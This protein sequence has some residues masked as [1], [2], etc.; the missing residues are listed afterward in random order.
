MEKQKFED[1]FQGLLKHFQSPGKYGQV[2]VMVGAGFSKNAV[3][4]SQN[5]VP[6]P[7]WD[8]LVALLAKDSPSITLGAKVILDQID[9]FEKLH[10]RVFLG[11]K[12]MEYV[13]W[14]S[15]RSGELHELLLEA[16][17]RDIFTTN[18]DN[19]IEDSLDRNQSN[20]RIS[21]QKILAP[22]ELSGSRPPRIIKLHGSFPDNQSLVISTRDYE[23]YELQRSAFVNTVRQ[24]LIEGPIVL[25][26][27]SGTDPNFIKW[28]SWILDN[29]NNMAQPVYFCT[30][31][32]SDKGEPQSE[33]SKKGVINLDLKYLLHSPPERASVGYP[34]ALKV[35]LGKIIGAQLPKGDDV[36]PK[37]PHRR[38]DLF[39]PQDLYVR[40]DL[41]IGVNQRDVLPKKIKRW[42]QFWLQQ[43]R[44]YPGWAQFPDKIKTNLWTQWENDL[45]NLVSSLRTDVDNPGIEKS[46]QLKAFSNIAWNMKKF[47]M[48][49][50]IKGITESAQSLALTYPEGLEDSEENRSMWKEL[51]WFLVSD[52]RLSHN[53]DDFQKFISRVPTDSISDDERAKL[54]FEKT[55]FAMNNC[56]IE[57]ANQAI[58]QWP[59]QQGS[60]KWALKKAGL[61]IELN[62]FIEAQKLLK[63]LPSIHQMIQD[64]LTEAV[65]WEIEG[66]RYLLVK[67]LSRS[68]KPFDFSFDCFLDWYE[69]EPLIAEIHPPE[70][71]RVMALQDEIQFNSETLRGVKSLHGKCFNSKEDLIAEV[72]TILD[73]PEF[74]QLV[75]KSIKSVRR[76]DPRGEEL[77]QH[78]AN[79]FDRIDSLKASLEA[80]FPRIMEHKKTTKLFDL[81]AESN[82][83]SIVSGFFSDTSD[84]N[85]TIPF[86]ATWP[87]YAMLTWL[88]DWGVPLSKFQP[89]TPALMRLLDLLG[90]NAR[91]CF[92]FL[93]RVRDEKLTNHYLTQVRLSLVETCEI[94]WIYDRLLQS[95][96]R[97][98]DAIQEIPASP[99]KDS[100]DL[101]WYLDTLSR[102][103]CR[104]SGK[105][106]ESVLE[107]AL[108][109]FALEQIR[110]LRGDGFTNLLRR[111]FD[112]MTDRQISAWMSKL[113]QFPILAEQE[114][115]AFVAHWFPNP[116][117]DIQLRK[118]E[119]P[120]SGRGAE[121]GPAIAGLLEKL[122]S[123]R[124]GVRG[125]AAFRLY[126]LMGNDWLTD[127]E[128]KSFLSSL[129][130]QTDDC[131]PSSVQL[132][133][134]AFLLTPK[135]AGPE[136]KK[137]YRD[138]LSRQFNEEVKQG[139]P[140][141]DRNLL[142][143]FTNATESLKSPDPVK[144]NDWSEL[145]F[146][147]M[148]RWIL[149]YYS[150]H[151]AQLQNGVNGVTYEKVIEEGCLTVSKFAHRFLS[152]ESKE[153]LLAIKKLHGITESHSQMKIK[154]LPAV[155]WF[156]L[157]GP[158]LAGKL[159]FDAS[160]D[161]S[162][163]VQL[164]AIVVLYWWILQEFS[165][166]DKVFA[167]ELLDL[168]VDAVFSSSPRNIMRNL[169]LVGDMVKRMQEFLLESQN[170]K[171][172]LNLFKLEKKAKIADQ[173]ELYFRK[174]NPSEFQIPIEYVM[175][176]RH[177]LFGTLSALQNDLPD[178]EFLTSLIEQGKQE[179]LNEI[180][181]LFED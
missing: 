128:K 114:G 168:W 126:F 31:D 6:M 92:I 149:R 36:W 84:S 122:R 37:T 73:A 59:D 132:F 136:I 131:W 108:E 45:L 32:E 55:Q 38:D 163:Q 5:L 14:G 152:P 165:S 79:P 161:E 167:A 113:L 76:E 74:L 75:K 7:D 35:F 104:L 106:L 121:M 56:D 154:L 93:L 13:A 47:S 44:L 29:L 81:Y 52:A 107:W 70:I 20:Q 157:E 153:G 96:K 61:L 177:A 158:S 94:E 112:N 78:S 101:N 2:S 146:I 87:A 86:D 125:E 42:N 49:L 151:S 24:A 72:S 4:V 150:A 57:A 142:V 10:S 28:R 68:L 103:C 179:S 144:I 82:T 139:E 51:L 109:I 22:S 155:S 54:Q 156:K 137:V 148:I 176:I 178:D 66:I 159:V 180:K 11:K 166:G 145:E 58:N 69:L 170:T 90:N 27:F 175:D 80:S 115:R 18:F 88:Y 30:Y 46:E 129:W 21:F 53:E 85:R 171:F 50:K 127:Q 100:S 1:S 130:E 141:K 34:D 39:E 111:V 169:G 48:P 120:R 15:Y 60:P 147:E 19:L 23:E 181:H 95:A 67:I 116:F 89:E 174:A 63:D 26:G 83:V 164:D 25:L 8:Q 9:N 134:F 160:C 33:E 17:W 12:V 3:P 118:V 71:G 110:G 105:Q 62:H 99:K 143:E 16:S 124:D 133:R 119:V 77:S 64:G 40:P 140:H 117:L 98:L 172:L 41:D 97:Y 138:W 173:W 43:R 65:A 135:P 123:D 91:V 162:P 102:L